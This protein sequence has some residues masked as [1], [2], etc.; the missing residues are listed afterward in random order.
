MPI[1]PDDGLF[2]SP[3]EKHA[4]ALSDLKPGAHILMVRATDAAGN[5]GTCD[6]VIPG[7]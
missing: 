1:F 2:D 4:I 6:L 5:L 3:S 7:R